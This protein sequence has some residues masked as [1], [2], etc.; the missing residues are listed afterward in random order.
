VKKD[1][2]SKK[3]KHSWKTERTGRFTICEEKKLNKILSLYCYFFRKGNQKKTDKF[4]I[5]KN[6]SEAQKEQQCKMATCMK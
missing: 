3:E 4:T 6:I 5:E 2:A 1:L